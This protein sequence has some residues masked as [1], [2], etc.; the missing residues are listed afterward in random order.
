MPNSDV[1]SAG[2]KT[3]KNQTAE[4]GDSNPTQSLENIG[5]SGNDSRIDSRTKVAACPD[6]SRI[7][8]AWAKLPPPLK[9]A[10]LAIVNSTE[11]G[12]NKGKLAPHF[13]NLPFNVPWEFPFKAETGDNYRVYQSEQGA[14]ITEVFCRGVLISL[15]VS[16]Q[17]NL[18]EWVRRNWY[19]I[20]NSGDDRHC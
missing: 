7:V 4:N 8:T 2:A 18:V 5:D 16:G 14:W 6:L 17:D 15:S 10:I 12:Q 1:N 3:H 9:A 19:D 11:S 13:H 20:V